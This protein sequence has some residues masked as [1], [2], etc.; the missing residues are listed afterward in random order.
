VPVSHPAPSWTGRIPGAGDRYLLAPLRSHTGEDVALSGGCAYSTLRRWWPA[1]T[2]LAFGLTGVEVF[3]CKGESLVVTL[4][5]HNA[6]LR[7]CSRD[8]GDNVDCLQ[9][10]HNLH[11]AQTD[12][13]V[14]LRLIRSCHDPPHNNWSFVLCD[15]R[16]RCTFQIGGSKRTQGELA[17]RRDHSLTGGPGLH[18][19]RRLSLA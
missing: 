10:L 17:P 12:W 3:F 18:R 11:V 16:R 8:R 5:Y 4:A 15:R 19:F 6:P 14:G 13:R 9:Y 7:R 1:Q 2:D